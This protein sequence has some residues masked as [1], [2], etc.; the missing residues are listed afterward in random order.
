MNKRDFARVSSELLE[1]AQDLMNRS[2]YDK[3]YDDYY[4]VVD[5]L[6]D[7]YW[8]ILDYDKRGEKK[9]TTDSVL[10]YIEYGEH[11]ES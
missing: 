9:E 2:F 5:F 3:R 10:G 4:T 8:L 11:V 6:D 1:D 7:G